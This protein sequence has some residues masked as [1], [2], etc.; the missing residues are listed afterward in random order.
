M[1]DTVA[2]GL[3]LDFLFWL[4]SKIPQTLACIITKY[5]SIYFEFMNYVT[6]SVSKLL[7]CDVGLLVLC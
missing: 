6:R 3:S 1:L 5:L 4:L 7:A 2:A